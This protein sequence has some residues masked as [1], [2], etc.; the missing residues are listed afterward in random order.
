MSCRLAVSCVIGMVGCAGWAADV[1]YWDMEQVTLPAG[2]VT[3]TVADAS[4][5]GN[6]GT[7]STNGEYAISGDVRDGGHSLRLIFTNRTGAVL[8]LPR[9]TPDPLTNTTEG[10]FQFLFKT[11]V[12]GAV[13]NNTTWWTLA[14]RSPSGSPAGRIYLAF[15]GGR[16][17]EAHG[18]FAGSSGRPYNSFRT[19][20]NTNATSWVTWD[21]TSWNYSMSEGGW[22]SYAITWGD[23]P[24][25]PGVRVYYDG[26]LMA[27]N[28]NYT[29]QLFTSVSV[30]L[31]FAGTGF[32]GGEILLDNIR[33]SDR[34]LGQEQLDALPPYWP[35]PVILWDMEGDALRQQ[36][37][38]GVGRLADA[39]RHKLFPG[40]LENS[41]AVLTNI[42]Y[43]GSQS[44]YFDYRKN[45]YVYLPLDL[46][47]TETFHNTLEVSFMVPPGGASGSAPTNGINT[48]LTRNIG[49]SNLGDVNIF[50]R[51][52]YA[53]AEFGGTAGPPGGN[54]YQ[55]IQVNID[56]GTGGTIPNVNY[57]PPGGV[58]EG[59]WHTF[60]LE[61]GRDVGGVNY[62]YDGVSAGS[63]T[64]YVGP[65]FNVKGNRFTLFARSY[66]NGAIFFDDLKVC[67][68]HPVY[69]TWSPP[70]GTMITVH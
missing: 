42:G 48:I 51:N 62:Y 41:D 33:F 69:G 59:V 63:H 66:A 11:P 7:L 53:S 30:D 70:K 34:A 47:F 9:R 32:K 36:G 15:S 29:G 46:P 23:N 49:G 60:K 43:S 20:F 45:P 14:Q 50:L 65:L 26:Y 37:E 68:A 4:G 64:G 27:S 55:F 58:T 19:S 2:I 67:I 1:F 8:N 24:S 61:W 44:L 52:G 22:H 54:P 3:G 38:D 10:T 25:R 18:G 56:D 35:E 57:Y 13:S 16:P 31:K 40:I 17:D 28:L 12:G 6:H 21:I 5:N 39:S